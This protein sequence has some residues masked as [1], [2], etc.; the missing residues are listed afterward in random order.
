MEAAR[1]IESK[2]KFSG[3]T[4]EVALQREKGREVKRKEHRENKFHVTKENR[5]NLNRFKKDYAITKLFA[6][7]IQYIV[8][9]AYH[10]SSVHVQVK[11][12]R[13]GITYYTF[14]FQN[15]Q[16]YIC[17]SSTVSTCNYSA[18]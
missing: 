11:D 10:G 6:N 17:L 13:N 9:G 5:E 3:L 1:P 7:D 2:V 18:I 14:R 12:C 15:L 16:K 8:V 4:L